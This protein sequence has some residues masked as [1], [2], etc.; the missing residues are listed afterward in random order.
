[1]AYRVISPFVDGPTGKRYAPGENYEGTS[2]RAQRL[3]DIHLLEGVI[4]A[5]PANAPEQVKKKGK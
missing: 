1:M 5:I 3:V 4:E 2:E